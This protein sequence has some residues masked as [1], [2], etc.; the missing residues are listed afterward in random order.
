MRREYRTPTEEEQKKLD[1]A[2]T[3]VQRGIEGEQDFLSKL[4]PTYAK[5]ARDEI[6]RGMKLRESVDRRARE[7]EAY[8]QAGYAKGGSIDGCAQRGKTKG[9][10]V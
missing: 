1:A 5:G 4:S 7:G 2:R 3:V 8:N 10:V 6:R 9:R